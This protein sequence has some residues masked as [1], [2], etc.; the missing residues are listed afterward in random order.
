MGFERSD[1]EAKLSHID[2]LEKRCVSLRVS[3]R[4][5]LRGECLDRQLGRLERA[6]I[7][8]R[9]VDD[10]D[11]TT[12]MRETPRARLRERAL[13]G[14]GS[15]AGRCQGRVRRGGSAWHAP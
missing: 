15:H 14:Y 10:R 2:D 9:Y 6:K 12:P 11:K 5:A 1:A 8:D 13:R 4:E 3:S 7:L